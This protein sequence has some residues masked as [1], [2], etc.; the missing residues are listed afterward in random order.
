MAHPTNCPANRN[1]SLKRMAR[2]LKAFERGE[3]EERKLADS[4]RSVRAHLDYF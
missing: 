2:R 3:I 4:L 1:R